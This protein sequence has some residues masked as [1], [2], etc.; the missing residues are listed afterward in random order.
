MSRARIVVAIVGISLIAAACAPSADPPGTTTAAAPD[1]TR[2][3]VAPATTTTTVAPTTTTTEPAPTEYPPGVVWEQSVVSDTVGRT[4]SAAKP[5]PTGWIITTNGTGVSSPEPAVFASTN[6]GEWTRVDL[7][8]ATAG[9]RVTDVV[10][11]PAGYVAIGFA[12]ERCTN[13]C[14]NG[15]G[16]VWLSQDGEDWELIEPPELTGPNK[17]TPR[18]IRVIDD[19]YVIVGRDEQNGTDWAAKVWSSTDGL[20]WELT[21]LLDDPEWPIQGIDRFDEWDGGYVITSSRTPCSVP[22]VH[23]VFGWGQ[24]LVRGTEAMAWA[25]PD[26]I[27]WTEMDL[28]AMGLIERFS[29]DACTEPG[30][31]TQEITDA[32]EGT[33]QG[34][35]GRLIWEGGIADTMEM[36]AATGTWEPSPAALPA[37]VVDR[38][39]LSGAPVH[40]L[41]DDVG[42]V[43][44][45][46]LGPYA[47]VWVPLARSQD[48]VTWQD[49]QSD[50]TEFPEMDDAF[51][52]LGSTFVVTNGT[53]LLTVYQGRTSY[54]GEEGPI[55]ALISGTAPIPDP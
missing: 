47:A 40:L 43:A 34:V 12:G 11:G 18:Q 53:E 51:T 6:A 44:A 13:G 55:M 19:R 29:E 9:T 33:M 1:T 8:L 4:T 38:A 41:A 52:S 45:T 30:Y 24:G 42:F 23:S 28:A 20:T 26:G 48:L 7:P 17:V 5:T 50:T 31:Y 15:N 22:I 37:S 35:G 49:W 3:T 2:T 54:A 27:E 10:Y 25:S 32:A 14:R 46:I 36:D 39:E 21:A 16:V